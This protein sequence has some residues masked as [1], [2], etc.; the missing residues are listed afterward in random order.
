MRATPPAIAESKQDLPRIFHSTYFTTAPDNIPSVVTVHDCIYEEN[1]ELIGRLDPVGGILQ[2]KQRCIRDASAIVVPSRAT[3]AALTTHY[4]TLT[5]AVHVIPEGVFPEI[6]TVASPRATLGANWSRRE[7]G[8][9]RPYILHVGGRGDYKDFLT[10]LAAF[11]DP[12]LF[13]TF[14]LV[15]VG[16]E[17]GPRPDELKALAV[18]SPEAKVA[19]LGQISDVQ[20]SVLYNGAAALVSASTVEGFGLPILEAAAVGT[21]IACTRIPAYI[22]TVGAVAQM[23]EPRDI[24]GCRLAILAAVDLRREA[25]K[26][27]GRE[28]YATFSW[29]QM[30]V[31]MTEVYQE[32]VE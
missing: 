18:L 30:A 29:Q 25:L 21:P 19:W 17:P 3:E 6:F 23:F 11:A 24:A 7:A 27:H 13:E 26:E 22:E 20:L 32:I 2:R 9:S 10:V 12:S 14:D 5:C 1:I 16:S 28:L 8:S 4:P 15:V 31:R